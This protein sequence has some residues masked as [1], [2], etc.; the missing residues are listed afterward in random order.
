MPIRK[1]KP[2]KRG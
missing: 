1:W 2:G